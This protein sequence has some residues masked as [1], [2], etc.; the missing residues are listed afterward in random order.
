MVETNAKKTV[1]HQAVWMLQ[2]NL[3]RDSEVAFTIAGLAV[4][5]DPNDFPAETVDDEYL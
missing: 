1:C 2:L 4:W 3:L 5:T